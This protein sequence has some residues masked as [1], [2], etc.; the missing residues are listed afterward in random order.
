MKDEGTNSIVRLIHP[1]GY[2]SWWVLFFK[3]MEVG[4]TICHNQVSSSPK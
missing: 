3:R 2:L 4:G 1:E